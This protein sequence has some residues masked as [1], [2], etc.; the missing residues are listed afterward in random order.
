L[1]KAGVPQGSVLG[2][3]F[4]LLYVN[5]MPTILNSTM[6]T[7]TDDTAVMEVGESFENSTRKL[8]SP[9]NKVFIWTEKD[10]E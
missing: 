7:F 9:M 10:S 8:Q 6:A 1:I 3:V 2:P 4:Y 5:D